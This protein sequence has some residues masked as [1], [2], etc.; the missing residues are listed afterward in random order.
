M[1]F[2]DRSK[3]TE[4]RGKTLEGTLSSEGK[5]QAEI[6]REAAAPAKALASQSAGAGVGV[7]TSRALRP[8]D[9]SQATQKDFRP[10]LGE[11]RVI[12]H[13]PPE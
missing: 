4:Y 1:T 10:F 9:V 2:I 12:A 8:Q 5:L 13:A 7:L 6:D 11:A 3:G